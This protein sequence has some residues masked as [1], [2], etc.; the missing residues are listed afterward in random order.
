MIPHI[1]CKFCRSKVAMTPDVWHC[2]QY[3]MSCN[4]AKKKCPTCKQCDLKNQGY[5]TPANPIINKPLKSR[6][7]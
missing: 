7:R 6:R 1:S 2:D 4:E 5:L 3:N